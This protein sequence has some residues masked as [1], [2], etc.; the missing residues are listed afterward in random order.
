M[1]TDKLTHSRFVVSISNIASIVIGSFK[2]LGPVALLG[3]FMIAYSLGIVALHEALAGT[4]FFTEI[5]TV[6][7]L[8]IQ[9]TLGVPITASMVLTA[10]HVMSVFGEPPSDSWE[11]AVVISAGGSW[12]L[13][14]PLLYVWPYIG[15]L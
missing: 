8:G 4:G 9:T 7:E 3:S 12:V 13:L 5:G 15:V 10:R 6:V 11:E 14:P 1:S 2:A